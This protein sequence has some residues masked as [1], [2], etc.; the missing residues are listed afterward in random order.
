MIDLAGSNA[1]MAEENRL[2][3]RRVGENSKKN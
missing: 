2:L 3:K 1:R